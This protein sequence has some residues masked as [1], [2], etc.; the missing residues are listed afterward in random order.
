MTGFFRH[1]ISCILHCQITLIMKKLLF[2]LCVSALVFAGCSKDDE[3]SDL[4]PDKEYCWKF[5]VHKTFEA[6]DATVSGFPKIDEQ[7][8]L[9]CGMTPSQAEQ[10]RESYYKESTGTL[11]GIPVKITVTASKELADI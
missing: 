11:D 8:W 9:R 4:S 6:L 1:I 10:K 3:G 2:L 5:T 7:T